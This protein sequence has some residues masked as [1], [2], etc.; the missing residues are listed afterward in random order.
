M[1]GLYITKEDIL[2]PE[3][4]GV[5]RKIYGQISA[6]KKSEINIDFVY[7]KGSKMVINNDSKKSY[8]S[9]FKRNLSMFSDILKFTDIT[10]YDFLYIRYP[11]STKDFI[12]FLKKIK[13]YNLKVFV[14]IPTFP[15]DDEIHNFKQKLKL[16]NDKIYRNFLKKFVDYIV[17]YSE[18][19]EIL[20]IKTIKIV[21]GIDVD[22]IPVRSPL[23]KNK[24]RIDLIGVANVS[25]W[26][27]YDRL[28]KGLEEYY[29]NKY[30][31]EVYFHI[32]GEGPELENLKLLTQNLKLDKFVIFHGFKTGKDLDELFNLADVGIGSLGMYRIGLKKGAILKLR[33]YC[34]RGLPFIYGYDD[35]DFDSFKYAFKVPNNSSIIHI[36]EIIDFY[37]KF[38]DRDY[39]NEIRKY[40]EKNLSWAVKLKPIIEKLSI[41]DFL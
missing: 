18:H 6:F 11:F 28:I 17:T 22:K 33:E 23:P 27:G 21:N 5:F 29:K 8:S 26:H 20:G 16:Y 32:V 38:K 7:F 19:D 3:M 31:K 14:E 4:N 2:N 40:A 13:S 25:K 12:S 35:S 9:K 24:N 1:K 39:I 30:E 15:Y 41:G 34:S 10:N 37:E 36:N